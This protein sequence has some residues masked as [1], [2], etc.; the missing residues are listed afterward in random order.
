MPTKIDADKYLCLPEKVNKNGFEAHL[1]FTKAN[2]IGYTG[3]T[4]RFPM[5]S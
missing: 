2:N 4:A 5:A 1:L 3:K